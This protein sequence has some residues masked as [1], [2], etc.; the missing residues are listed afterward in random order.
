MY[1][2]FI[3]PCWAPAPTVRLARNGEA[4]ARPHRI[5]DVQALLAEIAAPPSI[6]D[7]ERSIDLP[8]ELSRALDA[9]TVRQAA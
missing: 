1:A 7:R 3:A 9:W 2:T 5:R 8:V 6:V 4:M